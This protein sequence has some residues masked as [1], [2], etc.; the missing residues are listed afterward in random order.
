[1]N[2]FN[3]L[4]K[5]RHFSTVEKNTNTSDVKTEEKKFEFNVEKKKIFNKKTH[6]RNIDIDKKLDPSATLD[7]QDERELT[8][9]HKK[10]IFDKRYLNIQ[11]DWQKNLIKNKKKKA[12]TKERFE[13][14]V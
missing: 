3:Q 6:Y 7:D 12:F 1:M 13:N 11:D 5:I 2:K 4:N 8:D 14:Y 10:L 9:W